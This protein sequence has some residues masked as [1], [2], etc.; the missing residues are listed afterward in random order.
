MSTHQP[1]AG[2]TILAIRHGETAWNSDGRYQ[3]QA[4][5][6]LN[7]AGREQATRVARALAQEGVDAVYSSD[8]ARAAQT[9]RMLAEQAGVPLRLDADLR[10]Q[11]FGVFQGLLAREIEAR[12]PEAHRRWLRRE[13]DFG[14]PDGETRR[15]FSERCVGAVRRLAGEHPGQTLAIVCHGGV[16]DCL[17]RAAQG[18]LLDVP[19]TWALDNAAISRLRFDG[20]GLHIDEWGATSHLPR[21]DAGRVADLFPAP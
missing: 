10:E 11:H 5:V 6:A 18:L 8:L 13:P 20:R 16:L 12:W 21:K 9:A 2:T 3:G 15:C 14:P 1:F 7:A 17:Y 4:D 19:R